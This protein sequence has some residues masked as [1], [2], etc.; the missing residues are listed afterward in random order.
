MESIEYLQQ[1][2][3]PTRGYFLKMGGTVV[4]KRCRNRAVSKEHCVFAV[5]D[6]AALLKRLRQELH[7][8]PTAN[9]APRRVIN[10]IVLEQAAV[11][12]GQAGPPATA[13]CA[14]G[15][16]TSAEPTTV[17]ILRLVAVVSAGRTIARVLDAAQAPDSG[18]QF[19]ETMGR[20]PNKW[21]VTCAPKTLRAGWGADWYM[22]CLEDPPGALARKAWS[23]PSYSGIGAP[24]TAAL[25]SF[26]A[27]GPPW[28]AFVTAWP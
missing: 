4:C 20:W 8:G 21:C 10:E 9:A 17:S 27:G 26:E 6:F 15:P 18:R 5:R 16:W 2:V 24:T 13:I 14:C 19:C 25:L 7:C 23:S 22:Q 28:A 1:K 11:L 3:A 12:D